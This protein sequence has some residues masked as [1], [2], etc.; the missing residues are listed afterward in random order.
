MEAPLAST[1]K[2]FSF[3]G[4]GNM[5]KNKSAKAHTRAN[6]VDLEANTMAYKNS[7]WDALLDQHDSLAGSRNGSSPAATSRVLSSA[8]GVLGSLSNIPAKLTRSMS[9]KVKARRGVRK[10]GMGSVVDLEN[11]VVS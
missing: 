9:D 11:G 10:S 3:P 7:D 4:L 5:R 2:R 6:E 1:K 8:R